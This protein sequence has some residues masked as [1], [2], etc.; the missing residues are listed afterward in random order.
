VK[1]EGKN[2][3][4]VIIP[5]AGSGQRMGGGKPKQYL[6]LG[7]IPLLARSIRPFLALADIALVVVAVPAE[8]IE[9]T[10]TLCRQHLEADER[11]RVVAGGAT[12]QLSVQAGLAA[13][14]VE[15]GMVLVHD[16]AR[17]LVR[18]E[19]I[20]ACL[21]AALRDGAAIA[22]LEL[23]DTLKLATTNRRIAR[24]LPR[25]GL[26]RAQTPQAVRRDWLEQAYQQATQDNFQGTDEASLLEHAGLPVTLVP[27][28]ED[29]LKITRPEDLRLAEALISRQRTEDRGQNPLPAAP[30]PLAGVGGLRIGHGYD[31]HRLVTGRPLVLGGIIVPHH[32]G[33]DGHS[34]AD[35]LL[36]AL[37]D[38][39]LGALGLG[40]IGRHFPDSD[41]GLRGIDSM[42]LLG[43][44]LTQLRTA[45]ARL[46]NA[47]L[48][49]VCQAPRLASHIPAMR[50]RIALACGVTPAQINIKATTTEKMG[51]CGRGEGI[52][53]HAVALLCL[54][55]ATGKPS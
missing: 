7:G 25:E 29:N 10:R 44:V 5:A 28:G 18:E 1:G 34:D 24:T 17:P 33:L 43:R 40:D 49:I 23:T 41:P 2:R 26:W 3:T 27:S 36:H 42:L 45:S 15:I 16:G 30:P 39:L 19:L 37:M 13:L 8:R 51:F 53:A 32:L 14:P 38:A 20:R 6:T 48:T 47:D 50:D 46:L 4:A 22:A 55:T 11:L 54:D 31:A 35:V 9:A 12:R 52:A 21:E